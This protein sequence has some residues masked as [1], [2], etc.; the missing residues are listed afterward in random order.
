M[1]EL[2][3]RRTSSE[4][5]NMWLSDNLAPVLYRCVNNFVAAHVR[6]WLSDMLISMLICMLVRTLICTQLCA[7]MWAQNGI[8]H[9]SCMGVLFG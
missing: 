3:L 8:S 2:K 7:C 1:L 6:M 5:A 9:Q 4:A